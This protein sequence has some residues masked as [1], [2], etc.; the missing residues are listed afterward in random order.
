MDKETQN[1]G[2]QQ[3]KNLETQTETL[4]TN[5][6][7]RRQEMEKRISATEDTT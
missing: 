3:I 4:E 2:N 1:E 6:S 5:L 7:N